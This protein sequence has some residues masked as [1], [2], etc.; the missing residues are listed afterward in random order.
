MDSDICDLN[1]CLFVAAPTRPV[2][3][4]LPQTCSWAIPA[5]I[6]WRGSS[7]YDKDFEFSLL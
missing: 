2:Y 4:S 6:G 5:P 1:F 7:W 3:H